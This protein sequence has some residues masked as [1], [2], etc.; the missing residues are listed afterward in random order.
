MDKSHWMIYG[1]NGFTGELIARSAAAQRLKPILAGRNRASV[2]KLAHELSLPYRIFDLSDASAITAALTDCTVV[3]HCAG[4][5]Q[6]TARPMAEAAIAAKCHYLD[7]TGEVMVYEDLLTLRDAAKAAGVMLMPGVGFDVVP[8]DCVANLLKQQMPEAIK[9]E[10][11]FVGADQAAAGSLKTALRQMPSG[12]LVRENGE[13]KTIPFFSRSRRL[14]LAGKP[15]E[16]YCIPWGDLSTAYVSTGI[17][18]IA[19]YTAFPA[20]QAP[21]LKAARPLMPLLGN[22]LVLEI[23]DRLVDLFV[24][25]PAAEYMNS[26]KSYIWGEVTDAKGKHCALTIE[27]RDTYTV[28]VEAAL[29]IVSEILKGNHRPGFATCSQLFGPEFVFRLSDVHRL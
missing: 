1:A 9:L 25:P 16:V 29:L 2:E 15:H 22:K 8:T 17:A 14:E 27:I 26:A 20:S 7:I 10:L 11:A 19:V 21:V 4:P 12:S 24:R 18:N 5:F 3:L 28:T 6:D 23:V 13:L